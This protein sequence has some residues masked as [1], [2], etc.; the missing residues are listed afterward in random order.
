[1]QI[2]VVYPQIELRGDPVAVRRIGTAV[3]GLGFD[4]LLAYDHVLGAVHADRSPPLTGPYTEHDPFHDPLV[5]FAHLAAITEHIQFATGILILPQRQT[6]LVARQAADVDLFSGGRLRLGV[7]VGWSPVEYEALGQDFQTR[8][9]RQEE[10]IGLLRR[11]FTEPVVDFSGRFDR[12]DRAALVPKPTRSI[13]IWLGGSGDAALGRAA[14]LGDGFIF[15]GSRGIER[16]LAG[17]A[18]LRD[19]LAESGRP[20]EGFGAEYVVL[21]QGDLDTA[22]AEIDAWRAAGGTHISVATMGRGL[23]SADGHLDVLTTLANALNLTA[24]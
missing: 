20:V 12:I 10:Q 2:G 18:R 23:D 11:L 1:M 19:L 3:E 15:S 4:H 22:V 14:R 21:A 7:A 17:W 16:A 5:M 24:R 13:P 6:A 8:G 9:A